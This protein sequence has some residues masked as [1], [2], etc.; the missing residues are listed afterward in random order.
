MPST[1]I[2]NDQDEGVIRHWAAA[3]E[4]KHASLLT[5]KGDIAHNF[6]VHKRAQISNQCAFRDFHLKL[7]VAKAELLEIIESAAAVVAAKDD[8]AGII[9]TSD[10]TKPLPRRRAI[11]LHRLP[12]VGICKSHHHDHVSQ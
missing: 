6:R 5:D 7:I 1:A 11:E 8:Q 3:R 2:G 9:H 12:H 4:K 10:M